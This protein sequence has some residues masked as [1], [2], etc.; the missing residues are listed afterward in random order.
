MLKRKH[1]FPLILILLVAGGFLLRFWNVGQL[2]SGLN[3][4]EAALAYNALLLKETGKDEWGKTWPLALESFGDYKLPGYPWL[5]I[6]VYALIGYNDTAVRLPSVLAGTLLITAA[7]FFARKV[8]HI[9]Q[10]FS[11]LAAFFVA[12]EPVFFFYSRMAF[13]A[14]AALLFFVIALILLFQKKENVLRDFVALFCLTL[15]IFTYNTPLLLLPF[16]LIALVYWRGWSKWR[17]W[18]FSAVGIC[19]ILL[20]GLTSLLVLSKQ[21]SGITIFSDESIWKQSVDYYNHFSGIEQKILGN[22]VVFYGQIIVLHYVQTLSPSFLVQRGGTH[23]WHQL[24]GFAHFSWTIYVLGIMGIAV[25][26]W[27]IFFTKKRKKEFVV[28]AFFLL[29]SPLP[30]AITVDAPHATRSLFFFFLFIL[31]AIKGMELFTQKHRWFCILFPVIIFCVCVEG[32]NYFVH[33]FQQYPEESRQILKSS[34]EPIIQELEKD[35]AVK[36]VA[37]VDDGGYQYIL[38][39]WYLKMSP[40]VFFG[41]VDKHLPDRIGFRYGYKIGKYRFVVSPNDRFSNED[42]LLFWDAQKKTWIDQ[43]FSPGIRPPLQ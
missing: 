16:V 15:A 21:K 27:Q 29:I 18:L 7:Y 38:T 37:V 12:I 23:P 5:L 14:N 25:V 43:H 24:P 34:Y 11:L 20:I 33:Y 8:L 26:L 30:A 41:T 28:L 42:T 1:F 35:S 31:F 2:P 6:G 19:I 3:R 32:L 4:D 10:I 22:R 40:N 13:E 36:K 17:V 9:N 39:A